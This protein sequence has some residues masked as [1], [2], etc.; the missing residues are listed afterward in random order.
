MIFQ[1]LVVYFSLVV[2]FSLHSYSQASPEVRLLEVLKDLEERFDVT[3]SYADDLIND[4]MVAAGSSF[5]SIQ[6]WLDFLTQNTGLAFHRISENIITVSKDETFEPYQIS[7]T[8]KDAETNETIPFATISN[9]YSYTISNESGQ[10]ELPINRNGIDSIYVSQLAYMPSSFAIP[11]ETSQNFN[12]NLIPRFKTLP[13]I[14]VSNYLVSGISRGVSG[15]YFFKPKNQ[16]ILPGLSEPD[17]LFTIQAFPGIQSVGESVSDINIRGGTNDQNLVLW[18]GIRL[19]QS[20]HFFGLI[21]AFN[22]H[23]TNQVTVVKNGTSA[24]YGNGVSGTI[25]MKSAFDQPEKVSGE[26]GSNLLHSDFN[27]QAPLG[28]KT[29]F[30]IAGRRSLTDFFDTPTFNNYFERAFQNS[31]ISTSQ[32]SDSIVQSTNDFYFYDLNASL[33]YKPSP[34]NE[35]RVSAIHIFNQLSYTESKLSNGVLQEKVSEL[36]Q[37]STAG[38]VFFDRL[39]NEKVKTSFSGSISTYNLNAFN[40]DITNEQ[41]FNQ[42]NNVIDIAFSGKANIALTP[43]HD[44]ITGYTYNESGV[45]VS[46]VIDN[47]TFRNEI[48]EVLTSHIVFIESNASLL[49]EKTDLKSGVRFNYYPKLDDKFIAEPRLSVRHQLDDRF[50]LELTGEIKNQTKTQIIDLQTDFLG[51]EKRRWALSNNRDI[52]VLR[53]GQI[54]LGINYNKARLF[55]Q[56][57]GYYKKVNNIITSSQGFQNQFEGIRRAGNYETYG[58]ETLIQYTGESFSI[59]TSYVLARNQY[60][61]SGLTP[62]NFPNNLDITHNLFFGG[63]YQT[64]S[65]E[66]ST[67]IYWRTG[68]PITR[69]HTEQPT[70]SG[71]INFSDPNSERLQNYLR[72]DL[73]SIYHFSLSK[74]T[75]AQIGF[76]IWNLT[77]H[78]NIINEFYQVD[79]ENEAIKL[80]REAL[81]FTPN[82]MVRVSF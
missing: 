27:M 58:M 45:G 38:G 14:V 32:S 68:R 36:G 69:P 20:G 4:R 72:I 37:N 3:F 28:E 13:E 15:E 71:R 44:L 76:S 26:V 29:A 63:S 42:K 52:P 74:Q 57:E 54:S 23:V 11:K 33:R 43:R 62:P 51:V 75:K 17:I 64:G 81:K 56:V 50:A 31:Q 82:F 46:L 39:W 35:V 49:N 19:Y 7:G 21:S 59:W 24:E 48:L 25:L 60:G 73:S 34:K 55:T 65:L 9:S 66:L 10:Y 5:S 40:Q 70:A 47:P 22:P 41:T 77:N 12:L 16:Q 6:D 78:T 2:L 18:D 80:V 61:F 1:R 8:I 67:G 53:S 79:A 30:S